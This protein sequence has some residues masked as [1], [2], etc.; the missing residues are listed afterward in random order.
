MKNI[1]LMLTSSH[2]RTCDYIISKYDDIE[3]FRFNFDKFSSYKITVTSGGFEIK[4][5][6]RMVTSS[7]CKSIYFRKPVH[8]DLTSIFDE[9]Y[10][11]FAFR[12]AYSLIEG[13]AESFTG[14]CLSRPSDMRKSGN[15]VLQ[16]ILAKRIGLNSGCNGQVGSVQNFVSGVIKT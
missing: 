2:D 7:T 14:N 15:K 9:K 8:E 10:H 13:I 3:F 16:A 5:A 11:Q 12:E 1:V 6:Y 4:N